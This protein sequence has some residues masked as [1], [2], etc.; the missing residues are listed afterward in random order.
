MSTRPRGER[1]AWKTATG[2]SA[3]EASGRARAG[4]RPNATRCK[5]STHGR[6]KSSQNA[7]TTSLFQIACVR[8]WTTSSA[9]A[10]ARR[11][12]PAIL[13]MR[14]QGGRADAPAARVDRE[15]GERG[16]G[17][18]VAF[19]RKSRFSTK[20]GR[21]PVARGSASS[22][23]PGE[24]RGKMWEQ[25]ETRMAVPGER[26]KADERSLR[27]PARRLGRAALPL[28]QRRLLDD[29]APARAAPPKSR[30]AQAAASTTAMRWAAVEPFAGEIPV[31]AQLRARPR[32]SWPGRQRSATRS[33]RRS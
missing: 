22:P 26:V 30:S 32:G 23:W 13:R 17:F 1:A 18:S 27:S 11:T 20:K 3:A 25:R 16:R 15:R 28:H 14:I 9:S 2:E 19:H 5:A 7:K 6:A 31:A 33:S 21:R 29:R 4:R 8:A 10:L 24:Q 12:D